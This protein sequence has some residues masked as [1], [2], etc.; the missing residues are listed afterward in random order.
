MA[1]RQP[2]HMPVP[3]IMIEFSETVVLMAYG[4]VNSEQAR[5]MGT[6]PMAK[7]SSMPPASHSSLRASV[8]NPGRP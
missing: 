6:G 7:T 5:I 4:R 8:T 2:P 3:S 1:T